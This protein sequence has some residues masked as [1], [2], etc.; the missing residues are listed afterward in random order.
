M[1]MKK[2]SQIICTRNGNKEELIRNKKK[3]ILK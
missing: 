2:N 1:K 3:Q